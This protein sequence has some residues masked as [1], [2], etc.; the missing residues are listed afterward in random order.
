MG[1]LKARA[2]MV[3]GLS[4]LFYIFFDF[5][6]HASSLGAV[7]PFASDPYDAVG[8][9]GIQLALLS[10]LLTLIRAFRPYPRMEAEPGQILLTSRAGTIVLLSVTVTLSA[11]AIGLVG[12]IITGGASPVAWVLAGLLS[13]MALITLATGW[14]FFNIVH[15]TEYTFRLRPCARAGIIFGLAILI[16]AFYPLA[17]RDSSIPGGIFTVLTGMV[18]LFFPVW[19]FAVAILPATEFEYEDIFDDLSAIFQGWKKRLGRHSAP[20]TWLE[21]AAGLPPLRGLLGWLNPRR[22]RW[23]LVLLAGLAMGILLVMGETLAEGMSPNLSRVLLVVSVYVSLEGA[24][25]VMGYLVFGKYLGIY[26]AE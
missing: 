24:G 19:G 4:I 3:F 16:L 21:K 9:F 12:S 22:H 6:K 5:S 15:S 26:R 13:G 1:K 14:V 17:W 7:N 18:L 25:V 10:A 2:L 11:D 23:N 8:S 20:L